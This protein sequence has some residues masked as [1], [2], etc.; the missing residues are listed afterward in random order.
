MPSVSCNGGLP[1]NIGVNCNELISGELI[2]VL[3][4]SYAL[5]PI[6]TRLPGLPE[7]VVARL[8]PLLAID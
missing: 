3:Q 8:P 1:I 6:L 4:A 5:I 2:H 7:V